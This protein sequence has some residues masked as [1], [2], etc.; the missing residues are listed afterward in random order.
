MR[1]LLQ[2]PRYL[3]FA[4]EARSV[5]VERCRAKAEQGDAQAQVSLGERYFD[6]LGVSRDYE[7][8]FAWF[9]RAAE[10][11]HPRAQDNVGL[12]LFL[13]RGT[14]QDHVEACKWLLLARDQGDPKATDSL[15]R[16]SGKVTG[17][18]MAEA[19]RRAREWVE[20]W[21]SGLDTA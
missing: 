9:R 15:A 10:Q 11:G 5:A 20:S 7:Q 16:L 14:A 19:T 8:A 12:M 4:R 1:F 6:G 2:L 13:G 3:G 18:E 21:R 17:D